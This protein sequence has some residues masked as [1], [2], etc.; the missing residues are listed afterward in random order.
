MLL[1]RDNDLKLQ[2]LQRALTQAFEMTDLGFTHDYL[3]AEF[4]YHPTGIWIHQRGYIR[5]LL[6]KFRMQNCTTSTLPM[7]PGIKLRKDMKSIAFDSQL[8][9]SLVG[10]LIYITNTRPDIYY[11]IS[12]VSKYM[13]NLQETHWHAAKHILRYLKG[14]INFVLQFSTHGN[15]HLYF[16]ADADWGRDLD[17]RRSTSRILH[18]VGDSFIDWSSKLQ[19][20]LSLSTTEAKYHV[21][22]DTS[23]DILYLCRLLEELREDIT[24]PIPILSD[25][26][27]CIKLVDNPMLHARTK[28]IEIQHHFIQEQVKA[29]TTIVSYVPTCFQQADLLTKSLTYKPFS[30]NRKAIGIK[31][32]P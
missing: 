21:L 10:S 28:H 13:D 8:Y 32:L 16:Y 15:P 31:L 17:T 30:I 18:R 2:A 19:P 6:D 22:T 24:Q 7:D 3:G 20:T 11:T 14:T 29:G 25:N 4:E 1:T 26:K 9:R 23:K 12:Y 5:K 27:S